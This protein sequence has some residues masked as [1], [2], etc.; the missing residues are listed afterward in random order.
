MKFYSNQKGFTLL[1]LLITAIVIAIMVVILASMLLKVNE[2]SR[3]A[4]R[5]TDMSNLYQAI[6]TTIQSKEDKEKLFYI[7]C[8]QVK[9]PCEGSS[10]PLLQNTQQVNGEGWLKVTFDRKT[11]VSYVILPLDPLNDEEFNYQ[12]W[13]DGKSWKLATRLE[14]DN[15]K[16]KMKEDGGTDPTKYEL[17]Q[18]LNK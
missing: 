1:E 9:T 17:T 18:K 12:Y 14:S 6:Q 5:L 7:L 4:I 15:Y 16:L 3:D 2:R 8:S 10:F 13:S 11:V